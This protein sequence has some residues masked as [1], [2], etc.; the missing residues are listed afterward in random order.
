VTRNWGEQWKK[1]FK[2]IRVKQQHYR[3]TNMERYT[4]DSRDIVI[5]IDPGMALAPVNT[6]PPECAS[7]PLKMS[8]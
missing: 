8:L 1:Y 7:K 2:P 3:Q 5:E 6:P 4:P